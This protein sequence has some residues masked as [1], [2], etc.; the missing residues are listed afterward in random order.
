MSK[1]TDPI[2]GIWRDKDGRIIEPKDPELLDRY[3]KVEK[4]WERFYKHG[5]RTQLVELGIFAKKRK[6]ENL[7]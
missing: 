4:A 6:G 7:Q 2:G 3:L 5:D 1:F